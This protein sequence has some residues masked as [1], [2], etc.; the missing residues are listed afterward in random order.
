MAGRDLPATALAALLFTA[1][2]G[3]AQQFLPAELGKLP[4]R[5]EWETTWRTDHFEVMAPSMK[6]AR[7]GGRAKYLMFV[8]Q[9]EQDGWDKA[10]NSQYGFATVEKLE[11]AWLAHVRRGKNR[12]RD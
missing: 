1:A 6:L 2:A 9:G 8:A 12:R 10:A 3:T 5:E 7:K 4:P 11:A